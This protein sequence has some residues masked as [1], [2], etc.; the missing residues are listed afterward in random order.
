MGAEETEVDLGCLVGPFRLSVA[1]WVEGGREV[2]AG[3]KEPLEFGKERRRESR[4]SIRDKTRGQTVVS[5]DSIEVHLGECGGVDSGLGVGCEPSHLRERIREDLDAVVSVRCRELDDSV[6]RGHLPRTRRRSDG[7]KETVRLGSR[8]LVSD[9]RL[10]SFGVC[11]D[12]GSISLEE[13]KTTKQVMRLA[14]AAVSS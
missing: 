10:A 8:R 1:L 12:E 5:D 6:H 13:E 2:W 7:V 9:A 11:V 14:L 3:A 4:S